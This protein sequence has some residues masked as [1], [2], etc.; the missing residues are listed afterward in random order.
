MKKFFR[1]NNLLIISTFYVNY[2]FECHN[3]NFLF[4]NYTSV[5]Y[6]SII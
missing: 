1:H 5:Y 2:D 4:Y 6:D 3:F